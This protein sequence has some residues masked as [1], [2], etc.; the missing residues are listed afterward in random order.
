MRGK[1]WLVE[2]ERQLRALVQ[3]GKSFVEISKIMGKTRLSVKG[4]IFNLGLNSLIVATGPEVQQRVAT[5]IA[6]TTSPD[7]SASVGMLA[8]EVGSGRVVVSGVELKLPEKLPSIEDKLKVFD[9]ATVALERPDLSKTDVARLRAIILGVK[10]Y[11][12]LFAK[13]VDYR[14]L[15]EE[16]LELRKELANE[17][18]KQTK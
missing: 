7:A 15:E 1:P 6:T 13:Y 10:T 16:V 12:E 2:E 4:K 5:T 8:S 14:G 18:A 17:R 11:Q 3:E 9:A